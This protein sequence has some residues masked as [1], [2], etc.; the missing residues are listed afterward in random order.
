[1]KFASFAH[2]IEDLIEQ[3]DVK[4]TRIR[5]NN[6]LE[7]D[8]NAPKPDPQWERLLERE[9]A[10]SAERQA[11]EQAARAKRFEGMSAQQIAEAM[12]EDRRLGVKAK[13]DAAVLADERRRGL[14][15]VAGRK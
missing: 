10:K 7:P 2:Q 4:P 14:T 1:M 13:D 3:L 5:L 9:A 8:P 11:E 12:R 15:S 6:P